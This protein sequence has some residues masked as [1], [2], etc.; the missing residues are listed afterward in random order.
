MKFI[1]QPKYQI[2]RKYTIFCFCFLLS[3][4][5]SLA[6]KSVVSGIVADKATQAGIGNATITLKKTGEKSAGNSVTADSKGEFFFSGI[7]YGQYSLNISAVGYS[8]LQSIIDINAVESK[9]P[10]Q[11]LEKDAKSMENLTVVAKAAAV[12]QKDD[13]TQFSA[14]Q[15]KVNP[16]ATTEDLIKKMPGIT[17]DKNGTVTAQ[18]EQVKKV[19]VDGKDFFGDDA[20]AALKNIPAGVVDKIQVFDKLSDQAQLTGIDDGNS[21]KALNIITKTGLSNS[22]FGRIFAGAGTNETYSAGGNASFFK[23]DRR[24][25]VVGNFNNINQQNFGSQ[26]LLGITGNSSSRGMMGGGSRGMSG[27]NFRGPGGPAESFTVNQANGISTTNAIGINYGDKWKNTTVTGSYFFN[28]TNNNNESSVRSNIFEGNQFGLQNNTSSSDNFNHRINAR[29]EQKIDSNN[30][31]FFIPSISFQTNTSKSLSL[32]NSY[33][34]TEDSLFNSNASSINDKNGYNIRNNVMFRHSFRKKGRILSMG[35]T[36]TFTSND[37]ATN[38]DGDFRF[39]DNN[40]MPILPDSTQHQFIDAVNNGE[41]WSANVTYNEPLGK[42]GKSQLQIEYNPGLQ[43]NTSDQQTFKYDGSEYTIF[44]TSLTNEFNNK[45][46]TNNGGL[47]YRYTPSKDEQLSF[48]FNYQQSQLKSERIFPVVANVNQTFSNILPNASWRKKISNYANIRMFYR[49]TTIFPSI[50]QLQDV[51]NLSNP[52]AVST[53]NADLKQ[54]F[55]HYFGGRYTYT[56]TKNNRSFFTGMFVQ[57]SDDFISNATYITSSDSSI[58]DKIIIRKGSQFSKP[59]NLDGYVSL[60]SFMNYS[61]SVSAIKTTVNLNASLF[62][63]KLPGMINYILTNT[64]TYQYNA[65]FTLASNINEYVDYNINYNASI[66]KAQT[67][68]SS[69]TNNNYINHNLTGS[70]N[71]LSKNGW[72]IQNELTYQMFDGLGGN[73]NQTFTLWNAAIGKKCFKGK[74]GELKVSV[75]DILKQNQSIGRNITN[76]YLEDTRSMVLSQYFMMTFSYNLKNFGTAKKTETKEE[77]LPK[78]G[79]PGAY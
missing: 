74:T 9:I 18:G 72:F 40:G 57:Q 53:G 15:F 63:S 2:M 78:V 4:F 61:F 39:Y 29:I 37:G 36:G 70:L 44:D 48:G 8:P 67:I 77:F 16:D 20:T 41:S 69:T 52:T 66:N 43:K 11:L 6:Q 25:S 17:V 5:A 65:G 28:N 55:T 64:S 22:Q 54:S 10:M 24:V 32:N 73:F 56:N 19:T 13:T 59:I 27:G 75:F 35:V 50:I 3:G 26:D 79:Y 23:N 21:Q 71:L 45:I 58:Q 51:V 33:L 1:K 34:N 30:M 60:R 46:M 7:D 38:I 12:S 68:G 14:A 62:Y 49:A 31:L 42:K 47:T 76:T